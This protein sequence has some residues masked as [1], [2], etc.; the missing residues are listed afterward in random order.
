M[1]GKRV[2]LPFQP[3]RL[4][5]GDKPGD[6]IQP[7]TSVDPSVG[8]PGLQV[9]WSQEAEDPNSHHNN[10]GSKSFVWGPNIGAHRALVD[11][12]VHLW[13]RDLIA[14]GGWGGYRTEVQ[15]FLTKWKVGDYEQVDIDHEVLSAEVYCQPSND[16]LFWD[17]AGNVVPNA[18]GHKPSTTHMQFGWG[19]AEVFED[20]ALRFDAA[21]YHRL[22]DGVFKIPENDDFP[23]ETWGKP[24]PGHILRATL[25]AK[26]WVP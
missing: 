24:W 10:A 23:P 14:P 19:Q 9:F 3:V 4:K 6:T 16:T 15:G 22:I 21:Q 11:V 12:T 20:E 2:T 13:T 8:G 26:V 18:P 7:I 1:R 25:E 5:T 17:S